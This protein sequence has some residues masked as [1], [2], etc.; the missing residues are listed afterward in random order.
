MA[1]L[2]VFYRSWLG[3]NLSTT[4]R[5]RLREPDERARLTQPKDCDYTGHCA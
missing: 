2:F 5:H 3:Q 1:N 4:M